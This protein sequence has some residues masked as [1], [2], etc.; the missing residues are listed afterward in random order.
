MALIALNLGPRPTWQRDPCPAWCTAQHSECDHADDRV[1]HTDGISVSTIGRRRQMV[2]E[3]L[4][5]T[6]EEVDL[7]VGIARDDGQQN[8]W[9][10]IGSGPASCVEVQIDA[11]DEIVAAI[12]RLCDSR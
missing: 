10:Y 1:H 11:A 5:V 2:D 4:V 7:E 8:T 12:L 6:E 3:R 9:L